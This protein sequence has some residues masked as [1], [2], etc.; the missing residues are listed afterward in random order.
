MIGRVF[1]VQP[2]RTPSQNGVE[3]PKDLREPACGCLRN[4][5]SVRNATAAMLVRVPVTPK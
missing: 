5:R 3:G 2:C 4:Q 1:V